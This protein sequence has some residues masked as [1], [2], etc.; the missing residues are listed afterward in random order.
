M[1]H[2]IDIP[3]LVTPDPLTKPIIGFNVISELMKL[4]PYI[5]LNAPRHTLNDAFQS[6]PAVINSIMG[7]LQN[8]E[9]DEEV[10]VV[11]H[12][13]V[14]T[15]IPRQSSVM[16]M[17]RVRTAAPVQSETEV[18][19]QPDVGDLPQGL[20]PSEGLLKL[21]TGTCSKVSVQ[22]TNTTKRDISLNGRVIMGRLHQI[23][24]GG[25]VPLSRFWSRRLHASVLDTNFL[26][27][28]RKGRHHSVTVH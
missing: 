19:F 12:P 2:I 17:C 28:H 24:A 14:T 6:S 4:P 3:M 20:R 21:K 16:V 18:F 8:P 5:N 10:G 13:K 15:Q 25:V 7:L 9:D 1:P 22:I 27:L 26:R 23:S 11:R